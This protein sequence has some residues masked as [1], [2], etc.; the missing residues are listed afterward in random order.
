MRV[1]HD[2][3]ADALYVHLSNGEYHH[4]EDLDAERRVDFAANGGAVGIEF[5]NVSRG[6]DL[7]GVPAQAEVARALEKLGL[8]VLS[9][10]PSR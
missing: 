6:I 7:R 3:D 4:G 1:E 8:K 5:L 2:P 9:R 10:S